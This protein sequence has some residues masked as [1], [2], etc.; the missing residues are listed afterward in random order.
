MKGNELPYS[1][2]R[3]WRLRQ[4]L[5]GSIRHSSLSTTHTHPQPAQ[6]LSKEGSDSRIFTP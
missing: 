5:E 1:D 3:N 6:V 2:Q 4:G